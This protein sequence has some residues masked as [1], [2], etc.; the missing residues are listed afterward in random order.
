MAPDPDELVMLRSLFPRT[1]AFDDVP[2]VWAESCNIAYPR[3]LVERLGGLAEDLHVGE[4][5]ELALR[6]Q[7]LGA[8]FVGDERMRSYHAVDE[9]GL[10]DRLR[11]A[12]RWSDL[13][14]LM[15]RRPKL[16]SELT[17]GV[18]W[19]REHALLLLACAGVSAAQVGSRTSY[20]Q[21][22]GGGGAGRCVGA[23]GCS[24]C[25]GRSRAATMAA[26]CGA[27]RGG[28]HRCRRG[29]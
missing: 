15:S 1:V 18:F 2:R 6:G 16:R 14:L 28:W 3:A 26:G 8:P 9:G 21:R 11:E 23:G 5:T 7:A 27:R 20:F 19:K 10:R 25:R 4:D 13:P 22:G 12:R 29:C 17:L 24:C